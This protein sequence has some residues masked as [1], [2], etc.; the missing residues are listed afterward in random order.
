MDCQSCGQRQMCIRDSLNALLPGGEDCTWGGVGFPAQNS[1]IDLE[2]LSRQLRGGA[3]PGNQT[4]DLAVDLPGG[5]VPVDGG[6]VP[7]EHGGIGLLG[8]ILRCTA[9]SS[10]TQSLHRFGQGLGSQLRQPCGQRLGVLLFPN[11]CGLLQDHISGIQLL[12]HI[13]DGHARFR[14]PV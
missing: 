14:F 13:H 9:G 4:P 6:H 11:G 2:S 3:G 1:L 5:A 12:G 10:I 8:R 7:G